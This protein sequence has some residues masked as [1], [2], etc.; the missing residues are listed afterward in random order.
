ML[1]RRLL[2]ALLSLALALTTFGCTSEP[3]AD[4]SA[5]PAPAETSE[6]ADYASANPRELTYLTGT[7]TVTT[8]LVDIDNAAMTAAADQP[9]ATWECKVSGDTMTLRT[10]QHEYTGSLVPIGDNGWVY[11]ASATFR[12]EDG[13]T[14][15]STMLLN[16]SSPPDDNDTFSA[17]MSSSID[18]DVEGHLYSARWTVDGTRQ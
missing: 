1:S 8:E 14:W 5:E 15:T 12:D 2:R 6:P 18:S 3:D 16:A 7:W 9:G 11:D 10:D 13:Y 17:A 4:S